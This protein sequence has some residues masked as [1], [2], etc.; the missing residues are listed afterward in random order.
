MI[1]QEENNSEMNH[2]GTA[3]A[4]L[5]LRRMH[6][7]C[8]KHYTSMDMALCVNDRTLVHCTADLQAIM[9]PTC[10]ACHRLKWKWQASMGNPPAV[11]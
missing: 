5:Q 9:E 3:V 2:C 8:Q 10:R 1:Q 7:T 4:I 6:A 11:R